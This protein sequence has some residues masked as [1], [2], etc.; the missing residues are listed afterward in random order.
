VRFDFSALGFVGFL[1]NLMIAGFLLR[2]VSA[3]YHDTT[4]G[5]ALAF[6]Y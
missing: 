4:W 3:K 5:K 6:I 2:F 1:C